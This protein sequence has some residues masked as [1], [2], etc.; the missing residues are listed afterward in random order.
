MYS[1]DNIHALYEKTHTKRRRAERL[2]REKRKGKEGG[3][4]RKHTHN[5]TVLSTKGD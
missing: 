1:T 2:E 3:V 4:Q 5:Q